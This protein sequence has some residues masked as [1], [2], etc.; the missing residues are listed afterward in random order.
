MAIPPLTTITLT[1]PLPPVHS[2]PPPHTGFSW[3]TA[4]RCRWPL[5]LMPI[6]CSTASKSHWN[7]VCFP[8]SLLKM[9]LWA[10]GSDLTECRDLKKTVLSHHLTSIQIQ[11]PR[12]RVLPTLTNEFD[13]LVYIF[14]NTEYLDKRRFRFYIGKELFIFKQHFHPCFDHYRAWNTGK[15]MNIII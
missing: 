8:W 4:T 11:F 14:L 2:I 9:L 10:G 7:G 13:L 1:R 3:W 5:I 15:F 12:K 6:T